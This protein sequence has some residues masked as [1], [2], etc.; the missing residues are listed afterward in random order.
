MNK[1]QQLKCNAAMLTSR[2]LL[3]GGLCA[4]MMS[5]AFPMASEAYTGG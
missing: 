5:F 1:R 2:R 4:T 3:A